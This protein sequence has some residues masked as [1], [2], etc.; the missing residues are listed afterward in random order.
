MSLHR[1]SSV[2][3]SRKDTMVTANTS[4]NDRA[5]SAALIHSRASQHAQAVLECDAERQLQAIDECTD[6]NYDS[7]LS[8]V[9][10]TSTC[11]RTTRRPCGSSVFS[12]VDVEELSPWS[13]TVNR[14]SPDQLQQ[15]SYSSK[16]NRPRL[17]AEVSKDG[18]G[19][20]F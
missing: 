10:C 18:V 8:Q 3:S 19:T 17:N 11:S 6:S 16:T 7:V 1:V 14:V 5:S 4:G 12:V 13:T 15:L 9:T 2:A 20:F